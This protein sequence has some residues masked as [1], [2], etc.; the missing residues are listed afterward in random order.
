M[1]GKTI[2]R[3]KKN[4]NS[5]HKNIDM[6][7]S[8]YNNVNKNDNY[9]VNND[10]SNIINIVNIENEKK[11]KNYNGK[12]INDINEKLTIGRRRPRKLITTFTR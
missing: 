9:N 10:G 3:I 6:K 8:H 2:K 4:N 1:Y 11:R 7:C 5:Y 12:N